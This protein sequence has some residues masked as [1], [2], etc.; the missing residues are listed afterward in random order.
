[1]TVQS[2]TSQVNSHG[3]VILDSKEI[4]MAKFVGRRGDLKWGPYDYPVT[5]TQK[6]TLEGLHNIMKGVPRTNRGKMPAG[7]YGSQ[8]PSDG[9]IIV[10]LNHYS[11]T[12]HRNGRITSNR[13]KI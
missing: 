10:G 5:K 7:Y 12:V 6:I 11:V 8:R 9:G 3:L 4:L 13:E 1:M 2:V